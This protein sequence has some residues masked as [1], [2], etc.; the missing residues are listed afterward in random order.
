MGCDRNSR[1]SSESRQGQSTAKQP[2]GSPPIAPTDPSPSARRHSQSPP[3]TCAGEGPR[4]PR[5]PTSGSQRH[6]E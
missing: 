6:W 5:I 4:R 1:E 2:D 3:L